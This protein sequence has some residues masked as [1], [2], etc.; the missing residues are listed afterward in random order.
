MNGHEP[1]VK[2][3]IYYAEHSKQSMDVSARNCNGDTALHFASR[4][5]FHGIVQ[6]LVESGASI[7]VTNA[8]Q[9]NPLDVAHDIH[10]S[11]I[12]QRYVF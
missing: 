12:L 3:L 4:Y 1:C 6:L 5:G 2:A 10:V 8:R 7:S 9:R 11:R